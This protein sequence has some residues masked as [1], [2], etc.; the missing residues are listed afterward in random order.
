MILRKML[1]CQAASAA[2]LTFAA[3]KSVAIRK[4]EK[5]Q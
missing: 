2:N 3:F 5:T 4:H 1:I